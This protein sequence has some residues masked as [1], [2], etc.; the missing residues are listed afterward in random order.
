MRNYFTVLLDNKNVIEYD[1][2]QRLPGKQRD[3]L[4]Q[5]DKN[6]TAGIKLDN[7]TLVDP[8]QFTRVQYVTLRLLHAC[9]HGNQGIQTAMCAYLVSRSPELDKIVASKKNE[10]MNIEFIYAESASDQHSEST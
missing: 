6:M 7:E 2:Q 1:R 5:M 9:E 10:E 8:D 4:D 3:F